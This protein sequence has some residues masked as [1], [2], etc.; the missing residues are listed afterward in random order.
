MKKII[1]CLIVICALGCG[2]PKKL[3]TVDEKESSV[4]GISIRTITLSIFRNKPEVVYF[5][6]LDEKDENNLGAKLIPTNYTRGDYA[7]LI[8][9]LPGKYA[10]VASFFTQTENSYNTFYDAALIQ[11][12]VIEVG[13]NQIVYA[14]NFIIENQMKNLY[15]NIEQ[16]GD[17]AQLHYYNLLKSFM[18]G[19]NY[20][21]SLGTSSRTKED[22]KEFF[23][24]TKDYF[25]D[26]EWIPIISKAI[27]EVSK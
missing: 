15:Q 5:V 6:K 1:V 13:P 25:K 19:T 24:R 27:E 7:Y 8:N 12:S 2:L 11:S 14:G 21:G 20:C 16:N 4:I 3:R 23:K 10:A 26:S 17:R 9:A 18:Y 22:E